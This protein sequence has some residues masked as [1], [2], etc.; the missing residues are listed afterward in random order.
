MGGRS[1][2]SENGDRVFFWSNGNLTGDNPEGDP[3]AFLYDYP[4]DT[5]TQI[6]PADA[7]SRYG[8]NG[9]S[10]DYHSD[11]NRVVF[12][13]GASDTGA[14]YVYDISTGNLLITIP[15]DPPD[16]HILWGDEQ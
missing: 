2:L 10:F 4:T 13:R 7:Y 5:L 1:V 14:Y 3:Q 12:G 6:S 8:P 15:R 16:L 11:L 9:E